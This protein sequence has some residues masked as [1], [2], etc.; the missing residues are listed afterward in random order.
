MPMGGEIQD[1][2]IVET[3]NLEP[4]LFKKNKEKIQFVYAGAMLP[5]AYKPLEEIFKAV[6]KNK[7]FFNQ[8][9][10]HFIGTGKTPN[11]EAGYNI[12]P[13]AEKYGLWE[14][15][16]FEYPFRIPYLD[17]LVHLNIAD[18]VFI[19]GSTEAHYTPSKVYQA[20]LSKKPVL[21]VLHTDSSAVN[22][23]RKANAGV[24]LDFNGE[25]ALQLISE[26]FALALKDFIAFKNNF[27][28]EQINKDMFKDY[29]AFEVTKKLSLL[30]TETI[31][32]KD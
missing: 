6:V 3:L 11:D 8:V 19:L 26:N 7:E 32:K 27:K 22:V 14:N 5:K 31:N 18:A 10:F 17:V 23:I 16:I 9:E 25:Q 12:K 1:H 24:V 21:A 29:S 15:I 20:I 30:L 4:Y 28:E 2:E 13:L